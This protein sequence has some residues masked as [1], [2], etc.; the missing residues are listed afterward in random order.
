MSDS[1]LSLRGVSKSFFGVDALVDVSL[2]VRPGETFAILGPNGSGKSTLIEVAARTIE[3]DSGT[4]AI[5]GRSAMHLAHHQLAAIG[6]GRVFQTPLPIDGMRVADRLALA[7][8]AC[9]TTWERMKPGGITRT[10][11]TILEEFGSWAG[12]PIAIPAGDEWVGALSYVEQRHL[13][14]IIAAYIGRTVLLLDEPTAGLSAEER[15]PVVSLL[16]RLVAAGVAV[17]LV[18]HDLDFVRRVADRA[19]VIEQG[20]ILRTGSATE[21]L[22]SPELSEIYLGVAPADARG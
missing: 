7:R 17:L 13:E 6:V 9:S 15:L 3:P 16:R 21:V 4:V 10:G 2:D 14:L 19:C 11:R 12:A 8:Y 5:G 20:S 22:G 1:A 18:E